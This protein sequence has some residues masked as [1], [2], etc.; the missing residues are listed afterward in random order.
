MYKIIIISFLFCID[1]FGQF[2]II[3]N[4]HVD[5]IYYY[6]ESLLDFKQ[7]NYYEDSLIRKSISYSDNEIIDSSIYFYSD[8]SLMTYYYDLIDIDF[9]YI[10]IIKIDSGIFT[11][12]VAFNMYDSQMIDSS[13]YFYDENKNLISII[14]NYFTDLGIEKDTILYY[15]KSNGLIDYIN[16]QDPYEI[17]KYEYKYDFENNII[18]INIYY[19]GNL[20]PGDYATLYMNEMPAVSVLIKNKIYFNKYSEHNEY[21]RLKMYDIL[22]RKIKIYNKKSATIKIKI[23]QKRL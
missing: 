19:D 23:L 21:D 16:H 7:Y 3:S 8:S 1:A 14:N 20:I 13:I 22:G 6:Q 5:S 17:V 12:S 11:E 2:D 4:Y 9:S 15:Y 18:K 10:E